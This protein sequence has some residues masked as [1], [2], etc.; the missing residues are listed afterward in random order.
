MILA[1]SHLFTPLTIRGATLPNRIFVSPM[2]QYSSTDGF[3]ND[4]HLVHLGRRAVGGAG[5]GV[6]RGDGGA[7]PTA[8]SARTTSASG[9]TP[10][11]RCWRGSPGSSTPQ[12]SVAGIQ[13]AHAGR[14][15][16]TRRPWEGQRHAHGRRGRLDRRRSRRARSRSRTTY[17]LPQALTLGGHP[18]RRRRLRRRRDARLGGGL[19]RRRAPRG[20]RL[21]AARVPLA[22]QQH[23][24][25][26]RTAAPS[27]TAM[28][29]PA[30]GRARRCAHAWPERAAAVRAH[31]GHRLGRGRLGRR[32]VGRSRAAPGGA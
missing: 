20:A 5:A 25:T 15:A 3:A 17:P 1:M 7:R 27:R 9:T 30:R 8:A 31:L 28:R 6:R 22:A 4:W 10:T 18:R 29:A 11:S 2:C 32:G 24:A 13:L 26:T 21:P 12:G 14:K 19:P 16:S 23:A